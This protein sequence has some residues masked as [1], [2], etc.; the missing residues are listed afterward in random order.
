LRDARRSGFEE[1]LLCDASGQLVEGGGCNILL[2]RDG[3][4]HTPQLE[5][6]ALPGVMRGQV[7]ALAKALGWDVR[8]WRVTRDDVDAADEL[9]LSNSIIGIRRVVAIGERELTGAGE[10]FE[11][12]REAWRGRYG[13]DPV[14]VAG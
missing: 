2:V 14:V 8:E 6:G 4:L 12:L 7:L 1:T 9:W 5:S 13:W 10:R 11:A 3:V